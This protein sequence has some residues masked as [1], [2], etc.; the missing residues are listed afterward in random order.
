[1]TLDPVGLGFLSTLKPDRTHQHSPIGEISSASVVEIGWVV[2]TFVHIVHS[3]PASLI[4]RRKNINNTF[5]CS[6]ITH[7]G[8]D[9]PRGHASHRSPLVHRGNTT[10]G[11]R[12]RK[13][14]HEKRPTR[15]LSVILAQV[16][17]M[18][19][20]FV[21]NLGRTSEVQTTTLE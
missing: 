3:S 13:K 5:R 21:H 9:C 7:T 4:G 17:T 16:S 2:P 10:S 14:G 11:D 19:H 12:S 20:K 1:M 6:P 8:H 18:S 15:H